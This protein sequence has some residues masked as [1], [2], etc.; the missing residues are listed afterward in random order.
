MSDGLALGTRVAVVSLIP[1]TIGGES[2]V[3]TAGL[4]ALVGGGRKGR[5]MISTLRH[6]LRRTIVCGIV[7]P[8]ILRRI[9]EGAGPDHPEVPD[10]AAAAAQR[11]LEADARLRRQRE[12]FAERGRGD[13]RGPIPGLPNLRVDERLAEAE[14]RARAEAEPVVQ[15]AVYNAQHRSKLPGQLVRGEG[16]APIGGQPKTKWGKPVQARTRNNKRT[17]S[18]IIR[19]RTTNR[20]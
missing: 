3:P 11:T 2:A 6:Q 1:L 10:D 16:K 8:E 15:R 18:M 12:V 7:P 5:C 17:D 19:R 14:R 20:K 9:A 13:L 4:F